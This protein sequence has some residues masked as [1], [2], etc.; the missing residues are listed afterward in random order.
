MA[1]G[2]VTWD[3]CPRCKGLP[4]IKGCY[5]ATLTTP[6]GWSDVFLWE[7]GPKTLRYQHESK[8]ITLSID[9]AASNT[10]IKVYEGDDRPVGI[11]DKSLVTWDIT[12]TTP[13]WHIQLA[14]SASA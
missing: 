4:T 7:A 13:E 8:T 9:D 10:C 3:N 11:S 5:S 6:K 12:G 2:K 14:E 1:D